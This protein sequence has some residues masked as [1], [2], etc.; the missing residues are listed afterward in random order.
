MRI[1]AEGSQNLKRQGGN[2]VIVRLELKEPLRDQ[3]H[4][5]FCF[6]LSLY[7]SRPKQKPV[8]NLLLVAFCEALS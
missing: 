8:K 2:F 4:F 1:E 5:C 6:Y 3:Q 7:R